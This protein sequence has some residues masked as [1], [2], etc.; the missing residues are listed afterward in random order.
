MSCRIC[1]E[2]DRQGD[3]ISPC[4]C[5]GTVQFVHK[6]CL[7]QW[8][9]TCINP[10]NVVHCD[11]CHA[12]Y[13]FN[14]QL[15][16]YFYFLNR[17]FKIKTSLVILVRSFI[18]TATETLGFFSMMSLFGYFYGSVST[19]SLMI[20]KEL[21]KEGSL[22]ICFTYFIGCCCA[23]LYIIESQVEHQNVR[24]RSSLVDL[25]D[26]C[27]R[28]RVIHHYHHYESPASSKNSSKDSSEVPKKDHSFEYL[29]A[30]GIGLLLLVPS[31][32]YFVYS[33]FSIH[34]ERVRLEFEEA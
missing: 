23:L 25:L 6:D 14:S 27:T 29:M 30:S 5:I 32:I 20:S 10:Y 12:E 24:R 3:L 17:T 16:Q 26:F 4:S 13:R 34:R 21:I 19:G 8:R 11:I 2:S 15:F 33:R 31:S 1:L 9:T 22:G 28:P 7:R 18:K